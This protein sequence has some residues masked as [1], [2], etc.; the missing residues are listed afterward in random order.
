M[1]CSLVLLVC[2]DPPLQDLPGVTR[3]L[4]R[5]CLVSL[6]LCAGPACP[7]LWGLWASRTLLSVPLWPQLETVKAKGNSFLWKHPKSCGGNSW[8]EL[9]RSG[10]A[11]LQGLPGFFL[12]PVGFTGVLC[13]I[14]LGARSKG[15]ACNWN[16]IVPIVNSSRT[17]R[18]CIL[19][20][21][22]WSMNSHPMHNSTDTSAESNNFFE[23][24]RV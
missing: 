2:G 11:L 5:T 19:L 9:Q 1:C 17:V 16:D 12:L 4:C 18:T 20:A 6:V 7:G 14:F 24:K 23:N 21:F 10:W 13:P 15:N 22:S 8:W 3:A